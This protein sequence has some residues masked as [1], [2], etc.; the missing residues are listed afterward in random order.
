MLDFIDNML[1][2]LFITKVPGITS[3]LQ[4][5]FQPPD[6]DWRTYVSTLGKLALN[7]YLVELKGNREMRMSGR[8]QSV[9]LGSITETPFPRYVDVHYLITAWDPATA[10][11]AVEPTIVEHELLW[12]TT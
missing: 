10:G 6:D 11:P 2:Q 12:G 4:V 3:P 5:R 8:S 7:V 9:S 1:R